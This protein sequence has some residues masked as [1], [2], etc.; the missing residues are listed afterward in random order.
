MFG[1]DLTEYDKRV[2]QEEID[3]FLPKN[4]IDVHTH[5]Y[6]VASKKQKTGPV[7]WPSRVAIDNSVEDIT[8]TYKDLFPNQK[9]IPVIFGSPS[10]YLDIANAYCSEKSKEY[11]YP[12]LF[13]SHYNDRAEF[14]EEQVI[15]GGFQGLKPYLN[16]CKDGVVG[17]NADIYEFLNPEHLRVADKHGWKVMLHISKP[18]RLKDPSNIKEL[19]DIEQKYPNVKLIVA[20]IGRAYSPEDLGDAFETLKHTKNMLFDFCANTLPEATERCINA[21]GTKRIMFGSDLPIAKMRMYRIVENGYYINVVP[22][23][24][25]GDLTNAEH[26]RETD[27]KNVTNFMYEIIRGFKKTVNKL[28]LT[29]ADVEDIMCNN[30]AKL[31]NVKF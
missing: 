27:E 25:Y 3:G 11:G 19:M 14:I 1:F 9:V 18:D 16:N 28:E 31:F 8:K 26:M 23:G 4:I 2:Y 10:G 29:K 20:H 5:V 17:K 15:K 22:R 12:A 6:T 24:L 30:A 7:Y 21:V 13:L